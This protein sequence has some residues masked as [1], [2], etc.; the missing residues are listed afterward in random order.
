MNDP[1]VACD[2]NI[3]S[4]G[5]FSNTFGIPEW[6]VDAVHGFLSS[7]NTTYAA[8]LF[9]STGVSRGYPDI[10]LNGYVCA[11][12]TGKWLTTVYRRLNYAVVSNGAVQ[13]VA[14]S[15]ASAPAAAAMLA[16]VN[17]ARI[18]TGKSTIGFINPTVRR[19]PYSPRITVC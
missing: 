12:P 7:Y 2:T 18:A 8:D 14:G 4:G 16:A 11:C 17:D 15:S 13:L 10:A 3:Y 6:Q 1:E 9:N 19:S 5:G